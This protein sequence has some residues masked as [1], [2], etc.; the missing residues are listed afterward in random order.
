MYGPKVALRSKALAKAGLEDEKRIAA[1]K[2]NGVVG[3]I[4]RSMPTKPNPRQA[5]P[6]PMYTQRIRFLC[7]MCKLPYTQ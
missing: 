3:S 7:A 6:K 5:N 2:T 4:G 1:S